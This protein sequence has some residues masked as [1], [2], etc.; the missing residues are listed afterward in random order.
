MLPPILVELLRDDVSV[1]RLGGRLWTALPAD[2]RAA[3]YDVLAAV[4]DLVVSGRAYNRWIWGVERERYT[5]AI[6]AALAAAGDGVLLDAGA[7]SALF[8]APVYA[9]RPVR[10][11]LLDLSLGMLRRADARL[12]DDAPVALVQGDLSDLPFADASFDAVLHFGIPHV[13]PDLAPVVR[14]LGRVVRPGGTV[15]V[16]SLVRSGRRAGDGFLQVL[17]TAGEVARPRTAAEVAE[18]LAPIGAV[19]LREEGS[20]AFAVATRSP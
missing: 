10:A 7:G 15:H 11:V 13:L 6:D 3:H 19:A 2:R 5:R 16:A 9:A 18:A 14:E 4:Y 8:S 20:W 17:H 12:R 1:E